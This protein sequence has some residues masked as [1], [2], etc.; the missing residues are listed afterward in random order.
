MHNLFIIVHLYVVE[1]IH[2]E[3]NKRLALLYIFLKHV[4]LYFVGM[5]LLYQL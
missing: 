4:S 5:Y 3:Q 1:Y 2:I